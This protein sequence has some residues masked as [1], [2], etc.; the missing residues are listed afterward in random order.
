MA[1]RKSTAANEQ[2]VAE[3]L[4]TPHGRKMLAVADQG[5]AEIGRRRTGSQKP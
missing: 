5:L 2:P 3:A 4:N 1:K